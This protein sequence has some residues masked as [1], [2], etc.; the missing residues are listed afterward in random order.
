MRF[1]R[2]NTAVHVSVGPFM[3]NSD[4]VT[5]ENSLTVADITCEL[6]YDDDDNTAPNR[7]ALTLTASGGSN[8]MVPIT[9][10]AV[11]MY[12]L[13]LTAAN[14]N[15]G[16]CRAMLVFTDPDACAPVWHE[17]QILD[18]AVYDALYGTTEAGVS[19][20]NIIS[21]SVTDGTPTATNFE[22]GTSLTAQ[23]I[24][25]NDQLIGRV[26]IFDGNTTAALKAQAAVITDYIS[27]NGEIVVAAS[28][29]TTA[30]A[31]GDTFKI[32]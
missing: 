25:Q 8:D 4:G 7:V 24:N 19:K 18:A 31:S 28:A 14:T 16:P 29:L 13:E 12:D 23:G 32:Y 3:D 6:I 27:T 5:P 20:A 30:P 22:T 15:V 11:G 21:G 9:S 17:F 26:V 1:L 2:K 10:T